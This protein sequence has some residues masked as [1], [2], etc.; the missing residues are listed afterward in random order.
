MHLAAD[1]PLSMCLP[2]QVCCKQVKPLTAA[3][4]QQDRCIS[5]HLSDSCICLTTNAP[6]IMP[7]THASRCHI[8]D[9]PATAAPPLLL[10]QIYSQ[11]HLQAAR[12][13]PQV[14]WCWQ[15]GTQ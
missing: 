11:L 6:H 13:L 2:R 4:R 5:L 12:N 14:C 3:L 1:I 8:Q 15:Q 7:I 10:G 9:K